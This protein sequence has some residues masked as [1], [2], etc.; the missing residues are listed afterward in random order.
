MNKTLFIATLVALSISLGVSQAPAFSAKPSA[1]GKMEIKEIIGIANGSVVTVYVDEESE[2]IGAPRGRSGFVFSSDGYV[3]TNRHTIEDSKTVTVH[4]VDNTVY[5]TAIVG[6]DPATDLAVLKIKSNK[7]FRFLKL[8]DSAQVQPGDRVVA[9]GNPMVFAIVISSGII[10]AQDQNGGFF[11][12]DASINQGNSGGPLFNEKGEVIAVNTAIEVPRGGSS[13]IGFALPINTAKIIIS[14]LIE[15]GKVERGWI[16]VSI[17]DLT[18]DLVKSLGLADRK[19]VLVS[20]VL[21]DGP[22]DRAGIKKGDVIL[23]FDK[24]PV[25]VSKEMVKLVME[26]RPGETVLLDIYRSGETMSVPLKVGLRSE[27]EVAK[28]QEPPRQGAFQDDFFKKFFGQHTPTAPGKD[29]WTP[30]AKPE[31]AVQERA[32]SDVDEIP[33]FSARQRTRDLAVVIGIEA[34]QNV[35]ASDFS[36]SDAEL[37]KKYLRAMGFPERNIQM[38]TN[39]R[40]TK[41]G[42]EKSL[43]AWLPN[44]TKKDSRVFIYYSGHGAPEPATGDAYIVPYDGDPNY[45]SMTG[46]S[47]KRLYQS[48]GRLRAAEVIVV[49]DS[50][51][52]GS[53]GRSVLAK[54][55]R[56]LVMT[57]GTVSAPKN[58]AIMTAVEGV[59]ISTSSPEKRHGVFT[60]YFLKAVK[61]G[62]NNLADIYEYIKPQVE[63][64]ARGLNVEQSPSITPGVE[65]IKGR[66]VLVNQGP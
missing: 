42:I 29:S 63:D 33:E 65:K 51:F 39:D 55:A 62:K 40:A 43:E 59:Q 28:K 5:P 12:T 16:G 45:L 54:G 61:E 15:R 10:S 23:G 36:K 11:Q 35:P 19:G 47:L 3:V 20:E 52:S 48:M 13:R 32:V 31:A 2:K 58:V 34:Y 66:F 44:R 24:K 49:L 7:R 26:K 56:P 60:Y 27:F 6:T 50:C 64:E 53:G 9:A 8:G 17:Q 57:A 21:K 1:D 46:Y 18:E 37:V 14:D 41:S 25:T 22:A 30:P 38:I 4:F